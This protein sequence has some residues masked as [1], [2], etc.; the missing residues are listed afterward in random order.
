VD[1][2]GRHRYHFEADLT[3][4]DGEAVARVSKELYVRAKQGVRTAGE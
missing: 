4:A 2:L 3:N 1:R